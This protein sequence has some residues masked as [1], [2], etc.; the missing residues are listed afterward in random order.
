M[1]KFRRT[2]YLVDRSFQLKSLLMMISILLL[3]TMIV[4]AAVF[5]PT[6]Y[7]L[8]SDLPLEQR[9]DAAK[10]ILLLHSTIWPGI[11]AVIVLFGLLSI[12]L[13]HKVAGPLYRIKSALS[14]LTAGNYSVRVTLRKWDELIDLA[15][16]VNLF[17]ETLDVSRTALMLKQQ[18]VAEDLAALKREFSASSPDK[19]A[20]IKLVEKIEAANA[21]IIPV[22][23]PKGEI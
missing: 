23:M 12:Y 15:E 3:Q 19:S 22:V 5:A 17:S 8:Y 11:L 7:V 13:S 2:K 20:I 4:L 21:E 1:K 9:A 14:E 6:V 18:A 10:S 16:Q